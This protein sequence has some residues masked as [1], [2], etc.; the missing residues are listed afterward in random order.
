MEIEMS[1][2]FA[3]AAHPWRWLVSFFRIGVR[4]VRPQRNYVTSLSNYSIII[5]F[6]L[7]SGGAVAAPFSYSFT[8]PW[9]GVADIAGSG[10]TFEATLVVDNGGLTNA[11]QNYGAADLQSFSLTTGTFNL[12]AV[13]FDVFIIALPTDASGDLCV[14]A[15]RLG[16]LTPNFLVDF[17]FTQT[18][19]F[20]RVDE[21][22]G[23]GGSSNVSL[24]VARPTQVAEPATL[25]L[26][27]LGL[28]GLGA[29]RHRRKIAA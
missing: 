29:A 4:I 2:V 18:S 8:G 12:F 10:P 16:M 28:L 22:R 11:N 19:S 6:T 25:T 24:T 20:L 5:C 9:D 14:V 23:T 17:G 1:N 3:M 15:C 27:G 13:T 7:L 26:F 21:E